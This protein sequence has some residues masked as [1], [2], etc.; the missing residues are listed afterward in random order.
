MDYLSKCFRVGGKVMPSS[1]RLKGFAFEWFVR[2]ILKTC[3][4]KTI[5]PDGNVIYKGPQGIMI[6]GLGQPHNADILMS[7]PF[8]I[9]FH[10]PSRILVEC[11]CYGEEIGLPVIRGAHGL[12]E[13]I[14]S[15]EVVTPELLQKR[16]NYRRKGAAIYNHERYH[17]QIAV[18]SSSG[19]KLTAQEYAAT[20]RIPLI[21]FG[22]SVIYA[23]IRDYLSSMDEYENEL[24]REEKE[25]FEKFFKG[26]FEE[27][28][29]ESD[30]HR[31][32]F[33]HSFIGASEE[34]FERVYVGVL[35][36]GMLLFLYSDTDCG[37]INNFVNK[38][39][40]H[41]DNQYS[42]WRIR[43]E[44]YNNSWDFLFELPKKIYELWAEQNFSKDIALDIKEE[45]F[46]RILVFG[47][48]KRRRNFDFFVLELSPEFID[49][50][51]KQESI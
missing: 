18:A 31:T 41:W 24:N 44:Y 50:A 47:N 16:R 37:Y 48:K 11:K 12:R 4:F 28:T 38:C 33:F 30:S 3:G 7:P 45:Y 22:E 25:V 43:S 51:R 10:F 35:E 2:G 8:Q 46:K 9:P 20:H 27:L 42:S 49:R 34:I 14:N 15:F 26:E 40:I 36:N 13:D 17:Y 21:S 39:T 29:F 23:S 32:G 1:G 6:H 19:F 5:I